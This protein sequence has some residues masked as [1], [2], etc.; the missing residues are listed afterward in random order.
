MQPTRLNVFQKLTLHWDALHPYNAAQAMKLRGSPDRARLT[1]LWLETLQE[2]G[3]GRAAPVGGWCEWESADRSP[4]LAKLL[5]VAPGV[6]FSDLMTQ[7]LNRRFDNQTE[8]P[9]RAFVVEESD[10]YF[11][12]IVYHHWVADSYSIRMLL[13]EWFLRLHCPPRARRTTLNAARDGYWR[14]FGPSQSDWGPIRAF[15]EMS[16]W[17]ARFRRAMRMDAKHFRD[18]SV[19]FQL[20][21]APPGMID[22]VSRTARRKKVKV[23]DVFLAAMAEA[24]ARIAPIRKTPARM[25][26]ALGTIVDL[27]PAAKKNLAATFGLYLGFTSVFCRAEDLRAFEPL[28]ARIAQQNAMQKR[29]HSAESSMAR[30]LA[31]LIAAKRLSRPRLLEFYRKRLALAAGISNVNVTRDWPGEFYPDVL[32]DYVRV[33]PAGPMMPIVFTPTTLGDSFNFG[34]TCR[35]SAIDAPQAS[36]LAQGFQQS[37]E[38]FAS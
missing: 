29:T 23:N 4:E 37:L 34:L 7:Q 36:R 20:H 10:G 33:S 27:R 22:A 28:L 18:F 21:S 17:A 14:L 6:G 15:L 8:L 9:F 1:Q 2:L 16:R 3:L 12:G 32:M 25:D 11:A 19:N 26:L 5:D 24:T 35:A 38:R 13:R 31:G 30:M